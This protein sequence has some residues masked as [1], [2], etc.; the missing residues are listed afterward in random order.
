MHLFIHEY[1]KCAYRAPALKV[2]SSCFCSS[3]LVNKD[4]HFPSFDLYEI[5]TMEIIGKLLFK[6]ENY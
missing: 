6:G 2:A 3:V 4:S 5:L 1:Y